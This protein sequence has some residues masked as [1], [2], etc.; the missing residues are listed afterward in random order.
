VYVEFSYIEIRS[1]FILFGIDNV[2]H[3]YILSTSCVFW[4]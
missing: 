3:V 1:H 4:F 2:F